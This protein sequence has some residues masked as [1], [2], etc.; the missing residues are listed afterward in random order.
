[1]AGETGHHAA[2]AEDKVEGQSHPHPRSLV[3]DTSALRLVF[4]GYSTST[5]KRQLRDAGF[6]NDQ[7]AFQNAK[8]GLA[9]TMCHW[10]TGVMIADNG[11]LYAYVDILFFERKAHFS[12]VKA[13]LWARLCRYS[14]KKSAVSSYKSH[15]QH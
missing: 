2:E 11:P 3:V 1:M 8:L 13:R 4:C 5:V 9:N 7:L 14:F 10:N 15:L 6:S 12:Y